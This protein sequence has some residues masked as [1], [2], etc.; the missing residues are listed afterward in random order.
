MMGWMTLSVITQSVAEQLFQFLYVKILIITAVN[1]IE[2][3]LYVDVYLHYIGMNKG[4]IIKFC[5]NFY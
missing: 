3:P 2:I 5:M 4:S 1:H